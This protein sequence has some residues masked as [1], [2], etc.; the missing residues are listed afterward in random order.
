MHTYNPDS[1]EAEIRRSVQIRDQPGLHREFKSRVGYIEKPSLL[2]PSAR[3]KQLG[4]G[5]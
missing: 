3:K 5:S 4:L 1:Q 2:S